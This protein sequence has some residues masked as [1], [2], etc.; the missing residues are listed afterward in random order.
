MTPFSCAVANQAFCVEYLAQ[1]G[2]KLDKE[3]YPVPKDIDEE[4]GRLKLQAMGIAI[5]SLTDEQQKYL[6]SWDVGT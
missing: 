4:V 1:T 5:D 3:V 6:E 2:H